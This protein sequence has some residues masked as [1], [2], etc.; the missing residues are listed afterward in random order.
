MLSQLITEILYEK[1]LLLQQFESAATSCQDI[2]QKFAATNQC[3][4]VCCSTENL[5]APPH[6]IVGIVINQYQK[7]SAAA[8]LFRAQNTTERENHILLLQNKKMP[9]KIS[10]LLL[11]IRITDCLKNSGL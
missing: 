4:F 5:T 3:L 11:Q 1:M 9:T 7:G 8:A 6:V 2:K 10:S